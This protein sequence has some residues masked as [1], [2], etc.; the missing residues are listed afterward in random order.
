MTTYRVGLTFETGKNYLGRTA[1]EKAFHKLP[2]A[3]AWLHDAKQHHWH[4][5]KV[6]AKGHLLTTR[7]LETGHAPK[8]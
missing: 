4:L 7:E 8:S 5:C 6:D 1:A 2:G 3:S